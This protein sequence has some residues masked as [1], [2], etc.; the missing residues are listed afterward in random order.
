MIELARAYVERLAYRDMMKK[1]SYL[2]ESKEKEMLKKIAAF[3]ALTIIQEN[4]GWYLENDYMDGSKTKAIRRVLNKMLQEL[5]PD[6]EALVDG[7]GI[8]EAS[9]N[10]AILRS[11]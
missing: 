4:K 5:R 7:F 6:A 1:L 9:L 10:A 8:S 2:D 3:Y 11:N